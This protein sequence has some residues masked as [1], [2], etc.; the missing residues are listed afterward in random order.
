[1]SDKKYKVLFI[2]DDAFIQ[3]MYSVK[4]SQ[5]GFDAKF[6]SDVDAAIKILE[7]GFKPDVAVFDLIMPG[8]SG[9]DFMREGKSKNLLDDVVLIV[10]SNQSEKEDF[11]VA[12]ELG[13][14]EYIIK[15]NH[16]PSEVVDIILSTVKKHK[17]N[18]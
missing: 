2:D 15:A 9:F 17:N 16:I 1:M 18:V 10:L 4:F 6:A 11:K 3:E 8:K 12:Q 7:E 14:S 5:A 13:A